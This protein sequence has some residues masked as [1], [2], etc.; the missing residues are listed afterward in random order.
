MMQLIRLIKWSKL[1]QVLKVI[2][3]PLPIVLT[4]PNQEP[5]LEM[6]EDS[7]QFLDDN[8]RRSTRVTKPPVWMEDYTN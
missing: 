7:D 8:L 4:Q 3:T 5:G 1:F 6:Q 2:G